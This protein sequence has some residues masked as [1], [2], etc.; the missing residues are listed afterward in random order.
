MN[1]SNNLKSGQKA[2]AMQIL[3]LAVVIIL[4]AF[5][6]LLI[7]KSSASNIFNSGFK[8][9]QRS[10]KL[11]K[12]V[13]FVHSN[14]Y[15]IKSMVAASQDKQEIAKLSEQQ[16]ALIAEDIS[17]VK[18]ALESNISAEQKKFYQAI[19]DNLSEYEKS[20]LQVIRLAP[21]GTGTAYLSSANEKMEAITQLLTQLLDLESNVGEKGYSSSSIT[22]YIVSI[23]LLVLLGLSVVLVPSFVKKM[24]TNNVVEPLQETAG[25]L[26]EY[27]AGKY[28]RS[29]TWE[30]DDAI[31]DLIQSVNSLRSKMTSGAGP[32]QKTAAPEPAP[33]QK[34]TA[35]EPVV[36]PADDKTKSL[37]DMIKK[38]PDQAKDGDKLVTSSKKAI[39]KLQDI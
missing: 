18:K 4:V 13:N 5:V 29:L 8:D 30:A 9:Y 6:G 39:D 15:K 36:S 32:A 38:S 28:G 12:D 1:S 21:M 7:Q 11:L 23:I 26:R 17:V 19:L 16:V 25:V 22:F 24:M 14:L 34:A 10:T 33:A 31:G 20:A 2:L 35:P 37:S 3:I 27:A